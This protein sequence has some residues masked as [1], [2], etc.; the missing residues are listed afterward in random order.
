MTTV[1]QQNGTKSGEFLCVNPFFTHPRNSINAIQHPLSMPSTSDAARLFRTTPIEEFQ[2]F[3]CQGVPV[4]VT[5]AR[6]HLQG[7][8]TLESFITRFGMHKAILL[9]CKTDLTHESTV[10]DFFI[11][12]SKDCGRSQVL[13]LKVSVFC[14]GG[15]CLSYFM[16]LSPRAVFRMNFLSCLSLSWTPSHLK[17]SRVQIGCS[18]WLPIFQS[19]V[20]LLTLVSL[21]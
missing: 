7:D 8:W 5:G 17:I 21:P 20:W 14:F 11:D 1:L 9:D 19:T 2:A 12:F 13:E 18:I 3:W 6:S 4:I 16:R 10:A 15:I